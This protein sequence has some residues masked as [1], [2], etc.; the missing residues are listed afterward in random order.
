VFVCVFVCLG[1]GQTYLVSPVT[2]VKF[3]QARTGSVC[4]KC[5]F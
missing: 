2:L 1:G 4:V 5:S 3:T